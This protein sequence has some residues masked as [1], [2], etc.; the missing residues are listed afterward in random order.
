M[1]AFSLLHHVFVVC[2]STT[3]ESSTHSPV[4]VIASFRDFTM[5]SV[6][7]RV[8]FHQPIFFL[9]SVPKQNETNIRTGPCIGTQPFGS[10][11]IVW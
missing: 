7:G 4:L 10:A 9:S 3:C 8:V 6:S 5:L 2:S 11:A 1:Q